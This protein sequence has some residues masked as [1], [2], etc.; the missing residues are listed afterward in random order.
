M[1]DGPIRLRSRRT[2]R[3]GRRSGRWRLPLTG[4]ILALIIGAACWAPLAPR[5][6]APIVAVDPSL[7]GAGAQAAAGPGL[8][9]SPGRWRRWWCGWRDTPTPLATAVP[10]PVV[11]PTLTPGG[12]A[13]LAAIKSDRTA[14]WMKNHTETALRSGPNDSSV[15]FTTLPQW[16][17]LKQIESRPDWLLVDYAG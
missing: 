5:T 17:T 12:L 1:F 13:L 4:G 6:L 16:S 15:V 7:A 8:A 14:Q 11:V 3:A 9:H 2:I 10:T